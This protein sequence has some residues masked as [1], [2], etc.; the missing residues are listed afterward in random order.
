MER[1]VIKISPRKR[2]LVS[3]NIKSRVCHTCVG[4][5]TANRSKKNFVW[6]TIIE[7]LPSVP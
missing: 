5:F 2:Q 3:G 4:V 7:K 6:V 1:K